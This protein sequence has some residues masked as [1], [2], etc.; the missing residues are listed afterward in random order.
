MITE[1]LLNGSV[2][3]PKPIQKDDINKTGAWFLGSK[4]ENADWFSRMILEA[5][6]ANTDVRKSYFPED[7]NFITQE[8]KDSP[9]YQD[10]L[11]TLEKEY[12]KLLQELQKSAPFF[13]MR[14]VGH[15]LWDVNIP[16]ILG[17]F[18]A[19][20]Y[21]Q[22]NVAAETSPV[23]TLLEMQAGNDLCEMLGYKTTPIQAPNDQVLPVEEGIVGW[24]HITCDGT[25]ANIEGLWMARNLKF[26]IVAL[27]NAIKNEE[28]LA[29]LATLEI[30]N[31]AG[32]NKRIIDL[33]AWEALNMPID[34][35][36]AIPTIIANHYP[37]VTIENLEKTTA[38][39]SVQTL[40][41][42]NFYQKYLTGISQAPVAI[43]PNTQ[44]YSWPKAAAL[45]GIGEQNLRIVPNGKTTRMDI[46]RLEEI[47]ADCAENKIPLITAV[48]IIGTTQEGAVDDLEKLLQLRDKYRK[49][50]LEFTIHADAAWG[51]YF[52]S[53]IRSTDGSQDFSKLPISDYVARQYKALAHT[54]SITIDPHKAGYVPYPAG[55]LCYRNSAMRNLVSFKAPVVF[56]GGLDPTVGVYGVEGSKPGAAAA[57]V[58][59]SHRVIPTNQDGYG[60]IL[61]DCTFIAK[62]FYAQLACLDLEDNPFV[63]I[64]LI[65]TPAAKQGKSQR[66]VIDELLFLKSRIIDVP[67]QEIIADEPA[68]SLLRN[69]GQDQTIVT[70]MFNFK[71]ADGTL[72]TDP[73]K[74]SDLNNELYNRLSFHPWQDDIEKTP[75]IVTA[76]EF[77]P[78]NYCKK[79]MT[80]L[81]HRAGLS[82]MQ[83]VPLHFI[84]S[85]FM[86]P[87]ISS[88]N[89]GELLH[90]YIRVLKETVTDI[91]NE[92]YR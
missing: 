65:Q 16:S 67:N 76:S 60:K 23:T 86:N 38:K 34:E 5:I 8:V 29:A 58:Y 35:V 84:I 81:Y 10:S 72:N 3:Q 40:G 54:D 37:E 77:D 44:H 85:T 2:A 64:P 14:S 15:M 53:M 12:H 36:L 31:L 62:K 61:S 56:H 88:T 18:S 41:F 91:I 6:E 90:T 11:A 83:D 45:L 66:E 17:Y 68:M 22:N 78:N 7:P 9:E 49:K 4:G 92:K 51:G 1:T 13:S 55:G 75:L 24:G 74:M 43:T 63:C 26:Y 42:F 21:N 80:H 39:Y 28:S 27:Q 47:L 25:V 30:K 50:G 32:Q 89:Q 19:L 79:F 70:Y 87:W 52:P 48:A 71:N 59:L 57:S 46:E 69:M 73:K 33:D 82:E 20:L